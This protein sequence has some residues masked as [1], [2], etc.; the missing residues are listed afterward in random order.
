MN[1]NLCSDR[2]QSGGGNVFVN[3]EFHTKATNTIRDVCQDAV[4][5]EETDS[6]WAVGKDITE[7]VTSPG[8]TAV[9]QVNVEGEECIP[10]D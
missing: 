5:R 7:Q 6:A 4:G 3:K 2:V 9:S 8:S 1:E 10:V